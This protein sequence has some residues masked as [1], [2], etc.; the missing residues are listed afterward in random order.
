MSAWGGTTAT[1]YKGEI[2]SGSDGQLYVCVGTGAV[3]G[4]NPVGDS[5]T[6]WK[7]AYAAPTADAIWN[8]TAAGPVILDQSNGHTYRIKVTAGTLGVTQVT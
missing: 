7:L 3:I 1:Y 4:K 6:N 5:G 8:T 2:V